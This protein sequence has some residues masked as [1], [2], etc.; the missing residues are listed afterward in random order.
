MSGGGLLS[1][2]DIFKHELVP[3]AIV[4][5]KEEVEELKKLYG[6]RKEQLPWIRKNDPMCKALGAKPGDVIKIIRKSPVAGEA[7]AYRYVVPW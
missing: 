1:K 3:K 2:F 6:I 7:I 5:S 4:L